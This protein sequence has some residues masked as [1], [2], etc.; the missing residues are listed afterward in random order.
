MKHNIKHNHSYLS[1]F[2]LATNAL[3]LSS[4]RT[5]IPFTPSLY[6]SV[7]TRFDFEEIK[8]LIERKKINKII[9][10]ILDNEYKT[11]E[12]ILVKKSHKKT[13][14]SR[15]FERRNKKR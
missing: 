15:T 10:V 14:I 2:S 12:Y 5:P 8:K 9:F 4:T 1:L 6:L 11:K 3:F 13:E 7:N